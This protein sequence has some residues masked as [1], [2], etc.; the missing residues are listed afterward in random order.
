MAGHVDRHK[1]LAK[2]ILA[3]ERSRGIVER[4]DESTLMKM[5]ENVLRKQ[6]QLA[7]LE[8]VLARPELPEDIRTRFE[9]WKSYL[10]SD[11]SPW[12]TLNVIDADMLR[13]KHFRYV[14]NEN[15]PIPEGWA[16]TKKAQPW[17]KPK[18]PIADFFRDPSLLPKKP[19]GR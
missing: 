6:R 16:P 19:P 4:L 5:N 12:I 7:Q 17:R 11:K 10:I 13:R 15:K 3:Q 14:T 18:P 1:G 2:Q 8:E 9:R